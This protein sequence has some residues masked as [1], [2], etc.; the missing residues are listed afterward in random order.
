MPSVNTFFLLSESV[1]IWSMG[2]GETTVQGTLWTTNCHFDNMKQLILHQD[3]HINTLT[4]VI[5]SGDMQI[6]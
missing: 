3:L 5:V 1:Q 4:S 6:L 2:L